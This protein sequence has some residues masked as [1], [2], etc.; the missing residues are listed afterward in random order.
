MVASVHCKV[1]Y[2]LAAH[3]SVVAGAIW[4]TLILFLSSIALSSVAGEGTAMLD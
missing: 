1:V 4:I 2:S 3:R